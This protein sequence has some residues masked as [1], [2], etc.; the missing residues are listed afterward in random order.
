MNEKQFIVLSTIV[1]VVGIFTMYLLNKL[2]TI[3]NV[4]ISNIKKESGYVKVT[5]K[6]ISLSTSKKGTTFLSI[7]DASG[8]IK[9]VIFPGNINMKRKLRL[10]DT[11]TVIGEVQEYKGSL[12]II[13]KSVVVKENDH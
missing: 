8:V 12:E 1:I 6:I 7:S 2:V 4:K 3:P 5:G 10:N 9:V 13:A 11:I